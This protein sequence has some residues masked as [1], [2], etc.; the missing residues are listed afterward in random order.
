VHGTLAPTLAHAEPGLEET[1]IRFW[2]LVGVCVALLLTGEPARPVQAAPTE[3]VAARDRDEDVRAE[4]F[5]PPAAALAGLVGVILAARLRARR[6]GNTVRIAAPLL[7]LGLALGP[8]VMIGPRPLNRQP[9]PDAQEYADAA[10]HLAAGEGYVTTIY[11]NET[12]PPRY[13]PGFSL[14]LAPFAAVSSY[15]GNVQ[16][17]SKLL[18]MLYL[19]VTM[20][21]AWVVAGP[22]A[23]AVAV[24]LVGASPFA[25]RYASLVMSDAFAAALAVGALALIHR[26]STVR[27]AGAGLLAG[28]SILIRLSGVLTA[29]ALVLALWRRADWR[30]AWRGWAILAA[31]AGLGIV[32]VGLQQWWSFGNPLMTGYEYWLPEV[33]SFGLGYALDPHIR[34]DGSGVV[35]DSLDGM[36]FRWA[37]PCP[38]DDPLLLMYGLLFYPS[39]LLGLFW[40]FVPPLTTLPGLIEVWRRRHEPG[41]A[42]ALWLTVLTV[43]FHL[44]YWYVAARFM[45]GPATLLAIYTGAWAARLVERR[46]N[47]PAAPAKPVTEPRAA[48]AGAA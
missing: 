43:L 39:V 4:R 32:L 30:D 11:R 27:L 1:T 21:A 41:P 31:G 12:R 24:A 44:V 10:R 2:L 3:T 33:R 20:I 25:V 45:A 40:I 34:R 7:A 16:L 26:P 9:S 17:G 47:L 28:A 22:L 14:A 38:E 29:A 5:L 36:L 42:Y 46:A 23:A 35:A 48:G 15:P 6:L 19:V 18:T 8:L 37:C 13:P